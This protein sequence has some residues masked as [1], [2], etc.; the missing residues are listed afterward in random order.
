MSDLDD[1]VPPAP[2]GEPDDEDYGESIEVAL[3]ADLWPVRGRQGFY[4][5][6]YGGPVLNGVLV[7]ASMEQNAFLEYLRTGTHVPVA[8]EL[9]NVKEHTVKRWRALGMM[10]LDWIEAGEVGANPAMAL[11]DES[12]INLCAYFAAEMR[13]AEAKGENELVKVWHKAA[14]EGNW[15][16]ARDM[17]ARRWPDRWREQREQIA[18]GDRGLGVE[19]SVAVAPDLAKIIAALHEAGVTS[20]DLAIETTATEVEVIPPPR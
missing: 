2:P 20:H 5:S 1:R 7:P 17:L 15:R 10:H 12:F 9:A 18:T 8:C 4:R 14:K 6:R 16:A 11:G 3:C 19:G 13:R